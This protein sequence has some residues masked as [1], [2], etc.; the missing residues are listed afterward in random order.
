MIQVTFN[1]DKFR[2]YLGQRPWR[3]VSNSFCGRPGITYKTEY[4]TFIDEIHQWFID[5]NIEY[6]FA[7]ATL[8]TT[9]IVFQK[10]SDAILF[11]L[12]WL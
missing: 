2:E 9:D 8:E 11:K 6:S 4:C 1:D 12:T 3:R 10:E 5:N 7:D